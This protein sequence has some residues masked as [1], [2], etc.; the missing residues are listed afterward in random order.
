MADQISPDALEARL[1]LVDEHVQAEVERDL[2]KIMRT[3]GENPDFDDVPGTSSSRAG[4][5]S[6][7][8][9]PRLPADLE[10]E[11]PLDAGEGLLLRGVGVLPDEAARTDV[12]LG[13]EAL[14]A[15]VCTRP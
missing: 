11:G 6:A 3:W 15:R 8:T 1:R 14:A 7:S 9:R 5:G 4:K 13:L 2:D 10:H 12:Q